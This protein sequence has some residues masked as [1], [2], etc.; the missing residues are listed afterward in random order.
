MKVR[1]GGASPP[2]PHAE[3]PL[4][5]RTAIVAF[6][7]FFAAAVDLA[8]EGVTLATLQRAFPL[9]ALGGFGT[10]IF[11]TSRLLIAG[12][13][14]RDAVGGALTGLG[15]TALSA[16]GAAG[17]FAFRDG[18][19]GVLVASATLWALAALGHVVVTLLTVRRPPVRAPIRDTLSGPHVPIRLLEAGA[20]LYALASA[21]LVPLA[22][23]GVVAMASALHVVLVGFV[24]VTIMGVAAH[25][26][27]RF[28]HVA[29][30]RALLMALPLFALAGPGLVAAGL[31]G[32]RA[33]LRVG[34]LVEG[35]AFA[36]FG[37]MVVWML[38]RG[39]RP[40]PHHAL[41]ALAPA[42]I[43]VGG[44]LALA[45]AVGGAQAGR[46]ATHGLLNSFGFVGLFVLAASTD[47]Y[48][49]AL[50]AGA[51]PAKLHAAVALA[52]TSL[53]LGTAAVGSWTA[54]D[55]ATRA[56]MALYAAA[57]GWQLAGIVASHRRAGRVLARFVQDRSQKH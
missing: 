9:Y 18:S 51:K 19:P 32:P 39:K 41:Y 45:F 49:P 5:R 33:L 13:A 15:V 23:A 56:G 46:L 20:L 17:L 53:G 50:Q 21:A 48:G 11:G 2:R 26:L 22:Y 8:V 4:A 36:L 57:I 24:I 28:T 34:A 30:P 37:A 44:L 43:A 42:A 29:A 16:L 38:A 12:M 7:F 6:A 14:G 27:P 31:G 52:L 40:R 3:A 54:Q 35:V 25:I 1:V 10:L 55:A 47:L